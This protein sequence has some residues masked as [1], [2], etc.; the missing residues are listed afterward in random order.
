M[1]LGIL[2]IGILKFW[3]IIILKVWPGPGPW[4]QHCYKE[5]EKLRNQETCVILIIGLKVPGNY[6]DKFWF[7]RKSILLCEG[8]KPQNS[9]ISGFL[10]P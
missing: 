10:D 8:P 3:E 2:E 4:G 1:E 5:N 6:S 9:M 7:N